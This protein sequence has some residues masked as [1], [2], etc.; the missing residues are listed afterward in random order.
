MIDDEIQQLTKKIIA[1]EAELATWRKSAEYACEN[2]PPGC[3]RPGCGLAR[4]EV[5]RPRC[6]H[7][8]E[9]GGMVVGD[10]ET[11]DAIAVEAAGGAKGKA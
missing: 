5:A 11:C 2:P 1:L 6:V 3:E 7:G 8:I 4:D 10:C 9:W